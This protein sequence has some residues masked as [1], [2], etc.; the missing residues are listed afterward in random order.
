MLFLYI[1]FIHELIIVL[2][3]WFLLSK[4]GHRQFRNLRKASNTTGNARKTIWHGPFP[5]RR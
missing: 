2:L 1:Q 3:L 4:H 5:P